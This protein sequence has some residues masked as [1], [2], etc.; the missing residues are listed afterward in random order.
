MP[1]P[2]KLKCKLLTPEKL[3]YKLLTPSWM[4]DGQTGNG[5]M[6]GQD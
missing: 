4:Q 5:L 3:R 2:E 1:L 6:D